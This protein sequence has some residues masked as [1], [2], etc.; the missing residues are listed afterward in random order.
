MLTKKL[1]FKRLF[2][3]TILVTS[4][5]FLLP[6]GLLAE[7][8]KSSAPWYGHGL[9]GAPCT[10]NSGGYGPY[11]Y[12]NPSHRGK[13]LHLV[14]SAHFTKDVE[15]LKKGNT[16]SSVVVDLDYTIR[17]FPNHHRA[18]YAMMRYQLTRPHKAGSKFA[19]SECYFQ[20]AMSFSPSDYRVMQ[21]YANYLVKKKHPKMAVS[22]YK[23]ALS[24]PRAP[25]IINYSLGLLYFDMKLF[26]EAVEQA[27]IAYEGGVKKMKL[28]KKLKKIN[29]W[30]V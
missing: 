11:D 30:P 27:K 5:L 3:A 4:S 16:S 23:R 29:R 6:S 1:N 22:V 24:I 19:S 20:R 8:S 2:F 18:L 28:A 21:L 17:A 9:S 15:S 14:E 12:T 10:G 13:N 7:A 25:A 26:D